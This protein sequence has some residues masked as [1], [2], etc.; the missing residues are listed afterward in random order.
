MQAAVV[1]ATCNS[2]K[3]TS[4]HKL[5]TKIH[6]YPRVLL[7]QINRF[8][9]SRYNRNR[10]NNKLF[11]IR[12]QVKFGLVDY[13]LFCLIEHHGVSSESGHYTCFTRTQA[14]WFWCNDSRIIEKVL[15]KASQ[16]AYLMF[17]YK[18]D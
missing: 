11:A 4:R 15:P 6:D 9:F 10:K 18:R 16:D 3:I 17:Y 12:E 2:C 14:K 13:N 5:F 7:I 1:T 8:T